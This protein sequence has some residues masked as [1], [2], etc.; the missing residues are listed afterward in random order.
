MNSQQTGVNP[1]AAAAEGQR[2]G[3]PILPIRSVVP[4]AIEAGGPGVSA[5]T[6]SADSKNKPVTRPAQANLRPVYRDE[7]RWPH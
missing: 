7:L 1:S 5:S 3:K 6:A 2:P 4:D